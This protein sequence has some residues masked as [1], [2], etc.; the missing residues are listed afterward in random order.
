MAIKKPLALYGGRY[1][2]LTTGDTLGI[3][4]A[5]LTGSVLSFTQDA[6]YG[7][8]AAP[9]TGN[10]TGDVTSAILGGTVMVIHNSDTAPTFDDKF[11]K[12]SGSGVYLING[13]NYIFCI[14]VSDTQINYSINQAT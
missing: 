8:V 4:V 5:Q 11:K 1:K 3:P 14:Y 2:E 9:A 10:I 6:F 13:V 7:T 12:L